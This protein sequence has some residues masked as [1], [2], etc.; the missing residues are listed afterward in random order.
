M[1][2]ELASW[3]A[4]LPG[5]FV[6]RVP[7]DIWDAAWRNFQKH[8]NPGT[9]STQLDFMFRLQKSKYNLRKTAFGGWVLD[10]EAT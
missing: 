2:Y 7:S 6:G 1:T 9:V 8:G 10:R 4:L 3:V 5:P